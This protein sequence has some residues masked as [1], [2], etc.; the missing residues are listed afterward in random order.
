[1]VFSKPW[2]TDVVESLVDS[3]KAV[4]TKF[5]VNEA[6]PL[7]E[8]ARIAR[9]LGDTFIRSG[10]RFAEQCAFV[11]SRHTN[12]HESDAM[13]RL[14]SLQ[15]QGI[16]VQTTFDLLIRAFHMCPMLEFIDTNNAFHVV[17]T[18]RMSFA[19]ENELRVVHLNGQYH[20]QQI[21]PVG[22]YANTD[23]EILIKR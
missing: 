15:G 5:N 3:V 16:A 10:E 1:D 9:L 2:P 21:L 18:K 22:L 4:T 23:L 19:H 20:N 7:E 8:K 6:F 13:W 12:P 14:Y 17:L 11:N